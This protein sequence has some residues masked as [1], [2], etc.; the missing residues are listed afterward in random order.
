[1]SF[2][3]CLFPESSLCL[4]GCCGL[5][6]AQYGLLKLAGPLTAPRHK[7]LQLRASLLSHPSKNFSTKTTCFENGLQEAAIKWE[8]V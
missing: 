7:T 6:A 8:T 3:V 2:A 1:M 4:Q 5:C